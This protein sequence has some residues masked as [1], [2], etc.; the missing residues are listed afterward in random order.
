MLYDRWG[1]IARE[2]GSELALKRSSDGRAWSFAQLFEAADKLDDPG[3]KW[4]C[5]QGNGPEFIFELLRGWK[6]GRAVCPL[7]GGERAPEFALP[8]RNIAHVKRTSATTGAAR[9]V[10][11]TAEQLAADPANIVTTMALR[12]ERPNIG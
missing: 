8:P 4:V 6:F 12:G 3:E 5:P 2:G 7:E 10:A 9:F 1:E 11:F